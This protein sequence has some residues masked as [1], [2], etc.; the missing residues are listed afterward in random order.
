[1]AL[2]RL[3]SLPNLSLWTETHS[4]KQRLT[5]EIM[6]DRL[7]LYAVL[8]SIVMHIAVAMLVGRTSASRL[9]LPA[10]GLPLERMLEVNLV[11]NPYEA[12]RRAQHKSVAMSRSPHVPVDNDDRVVSTPSTGSMLGA[13]KLSAMQPRQVSPTPRNPGDKLN[14][15]STSANGDLGGKW[16]GGRTP[17]GYVPGGDS[18]R[19]IGSGNGPGVAPPDPNP[20]A[21]DGSNIRP[22][23]SREPEPRRVTVRVCDVSGMLAGDNCKDTHMQTFVE[24]QQ[25]ERRCTRCK[26]QESEHRSI[27]AEK[28]D[29]VLIR[30]SRVSVPSSVQEGLN[31]IVEVEY[32]VT[33]TGSVSAVSISRSSGNKAVDRAVVNAASELRYKPATQGGVPRSVRMSRIYRINT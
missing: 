2:G 31:L 29:P 20:D 18:G 8:I 7:L 15:G 26:A 32:T 28:S 4:A 10:V 9:N 14:I 19:G 25:P 27:L 30:D 11:K 1:M 17:V 12:T 5:E 13:G 16:S 33:E 21:S 3:L 22:S 6:R 24:G 23:P